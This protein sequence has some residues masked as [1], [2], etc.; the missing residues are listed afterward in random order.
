MRRLIGVAVAGL[1][2]AP[3]ALACPGVRQRERAA[4]NANA[5]RQGARVIRCHPGEDG[6]TFVFSRGSESTTPG[7]RDLLCSETILRIAQ[8]SMGHQVQFCGWTEDA[9]ERRNGTIRVHEFGAL[10]CQILGSM[11]PA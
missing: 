3:S 9:H 2:L 5:A 10:G 11:N 6:G 8:F 7:D 4:I 1:A